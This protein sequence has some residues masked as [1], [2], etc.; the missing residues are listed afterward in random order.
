MQSYFQHIFKTKRNIQMKAFTES[1]VS[2]QGE[3]NKQLTSHQQPPRASKSVLQHVGSYG[4]VRITRVR[5]AQAKK[6]NELETESSRMQY[7]DFKCSQQVW[8]T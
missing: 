2:E 7:K 5:K 3:T 8:Q 1:A 4:Q 6:K